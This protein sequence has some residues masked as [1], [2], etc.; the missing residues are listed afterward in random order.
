MPRPAKRL[1]M[2]A[3]DFVALI[4]ILWVVLSLRFNRFFWPNFEQGLIMVAAPLIA[5]PIFVRLGLYRSVLRYLPER[6]IWTVTQAMSIATLVWITLAFMTSVTGM[7]GIPRSVPIAYWA[8][9]IGVIVAS[10]FGAKRFLWGRPRAHLLSNQT[11]IYGTGDAA[12]QLASALRSTNER[13]VSG[14]ITDDPTLHGMDIMGIRVYPPQDIPA[15]VA[16][17]GVNEII[18]AAAASAASGATCWPPSGAPPS[19]FAFCRRSPT[20]RRA[21]MSLA[22][23]VISTS[24]IFLDAPKFRP[25]RRCCGIRSRVR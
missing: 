6:A 15:L 18:I 19:K 3:F 17:F 10:R 22:A 2:I 14:F 24:R 23:C 16:N 25:I 20:S 9:G 4:L 1:A 21:N 12:T 8:V 5:I 11:L 13:L 7:E